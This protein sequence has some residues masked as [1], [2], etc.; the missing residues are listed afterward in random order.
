MAN[1]VQEIVLKLTIDN[2]EY[3]A[4]I[5]V[6]KGT[7]VE[8]VKLIDP[9]EQKFENA[10]KKITA[11][12]SKY[13][14]ANEQSVKELTEW[15][16][17]QDISLEMIEKTITKLQTETKALDINSEHWQK[18]MA[19]VENMRAAQSKIIT[20]Y[21]QSNA[22]HGRMTTGISSMNMAIGQF[23]FLIGDADMF[24]MNFR[25]G[26]MSVA[27][28]FPMVIQFMQYARD[29]AAKMNKTLGQ[30]FFE[31]IKGPGGL[32]L[33][34]NA[35]MFAMNVLARVF[36]GTTETVKD[37]QEEIKKLRAEYEKLTREQ[38]QNKLV[39]EQQKLRELEEKYPGTKYAGG[40]SGAGYGSGMTGF[41]LSYKVSGEDRFG[42]DYKDYQ[43]AQNNVKAL[44]ETLFTLG[45][46][47]NIENRISINRQRLKDLNRDNLSLYKD[48]ASTYDE[49]KQRLNEWIAADEKL[50]DT[51]KKNTRAI[52][53]QKRFE[54]SIAKTSAE[55][56]KQELIRQAELELAGKDYFA[57]LTD[58]ETAQDA[59]N[60]HLQ[61][62]H[63]LKNQTELDGWN[64]AK[65]VMEKNLE[66]MK[67]KLDEEEKIREDA[68]NKALANRKRRAEAQDKWE[69]AKIDF[70]GE[71]SYKFESD[72]FE[73]RRK[74]L[75]Y[76]ENRDLQRA[77][78]Y[79]ASEEMMTNIKKFYAEQRALIDYEETAHYL[80]LWSNTLGQLSS[81]F[82]KHTAAYKL[83]ATAQVWIETYKGIAALYAPPPVGVGPV[84]AP[85]MTGA[86]LGMGALQSANIMKQ[87]TD[88]K[89][90]ATGGIL[91]EGKAG[92][93]EGTHKEIIAP[94]KDFI[95][96]V[97]DLVTRSQIAIV[98]GYSG[99]SAS[100]SSAP[101]IN[102]IDELN[103]N[104]KKLAERPSRAFLDNDEAMKIGD[105]YDYETR[106][107]IG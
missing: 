72:P 27:N 45:D 93:F 36:E 50:I 94:E 1:T 61:S 102:K 81:V 10:Y 76:E 33:G 73:R 70:E 59:Y 25:M 18:S 8:L 71:S 31:S 84:L 26:M 91:P 16:R 28:N 66:M 104:I 106:R 7:L 19:A 100:A 23:G 103:D 107:S 35:A 105:H 30:A 32:L 5:N 58:Y 21:D 68:A 96:V 67:K 51:A 53:E 47:E 88:I 64:F 13:N 17:T 69:K 44:K 40:S 49:I 85:F 37:Q 20:T 99:G 77:A 54:D 90:F 74:E 42:T 86:L 11:E 9:M 92:F 29:E 55:L 56:F 87:N 4:T 12:L 62:F 97:N 95:S 43:A 101:L 38:L 75:E 79:G 14:Q 41:K 24:L 60:T 52:N 89:G 82:S 57:L 65:D 63:Q 83:L 48:V 6:S 80:G 3:Q 46:I 34:V 15:I 2:K 39:G 78:M 98:G 22:T